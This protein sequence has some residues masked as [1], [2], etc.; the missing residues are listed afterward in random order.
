M[1]L[2]TA[3]LADIKAQTDAGAGLYVVQD[4]D[5]ETLA[6]FVLRIDDFAEHSEGVI[7]AAGGAAD[8]DLT[9]TILP[10]IETLFSGVKFIRMHTARP[11]LAK[12]AAAQGYQV[13]EIILSKAV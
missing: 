9:S 10:V 7:V 13:R 2:S 6:A 8:V 11:G 3:T 5:A 4:E 12:K 1:A